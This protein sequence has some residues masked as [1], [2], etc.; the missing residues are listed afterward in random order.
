MTRSCGALAWT[1]GPPSSR[2]ST[3]TGTTPRRTNRPGARGDRRRSGSMVLTQGTGRTR[4]AVAALAF[5]AAAPCTRASF[6]EYFMTQAKEPKRL[7]AFSKFG[8]R[9][10]TAVQY[11][12][13]DWLLFGSEIDGLPPDAHE[14]SDLIVRI[15]SIE[16][17]VRSLNLVGS[18]RTRSPPPLH[19]VRSA[20]VAGAERRAPH[21][22][23][24]RGHWSVRVP[25]PDERAQP[26]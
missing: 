12:P 2:R 24:L 14:A 16:K 23:D 8:S 21:A 3:R 4:R 6:Y 20:V 13:G 18:Q 17:H 26:C 9:S 5:V 22:G 25:P 11:Q 15:P 10:H 7:I 19:A 1:T